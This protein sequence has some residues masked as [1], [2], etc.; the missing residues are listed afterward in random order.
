MNFLKYYSHKSCSATQ[1]YVR[2]GLEKKVQ[3][4]KLTVWTILS[5]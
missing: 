2:N 4:N 5:F 1:V 3:K